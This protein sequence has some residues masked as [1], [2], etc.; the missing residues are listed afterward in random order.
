MDRRV[1]LLVVTLVGVV[2]LQ[3]GALIVLEHRQAG[4]ERVSSESSASTPATPT[5]T[6]GSNPATVS[7]TVYAFDES[8][9]EVRS[10]T[11]HVTPTEG[12]SLYFDMTAVRPTARFARSLQYA[13][14]A[15]RR[16]ADV[17]GVKIRIDGP[18]SW[19]T[20]GGGSAALPVAAA[21]TATDRCYRLD[22]SV[23]S[24]GALDGE[25]Q[26]VPIDHVRPKA[27]AAR[28]AGT[29]RLVVPAGQTVDIDGIDVV[30]TDRFDETSPLLQ[31]TRSC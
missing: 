16:I 19:E 2:L 21:I 12:E 5:N 29:T 22:P 3:S 6:T 27:E 28:E 30:G 14:R 23:A 25:G 15:A 31:Q 13:H 18:D 11:I 9:E 17:G 20:I 8:A 24:T 4:P 10:A 7:V 1:V 26:V